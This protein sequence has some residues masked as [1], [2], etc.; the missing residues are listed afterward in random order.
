MAKKDSTTTA[1]IIRFLAIILLFFKKN[2]VLIFPLIIVCLVALLTILKIS[3]TSVGMY[4]EKLYGDGKDSSLIFNHPRSIRSDEWGVNT[5]YVVSQA[6]E[7]FPTTNTSPGNGQDVAFTFDVPTADWSALFKLHNAPFFVLPIEN[8]FALKWWLLAAL[9]MLASYAFVLTLLP[10]RYLLASLISV[11]VFLSPFI[12]WWYQSGSILPITYGLLIATLAIYI[13][14]AKQN[15]SHLKIT[16]AVGALTYALT[17]FAFLLYI[18]FILPIAL[19]VGVFLLGFFLNEQRDDKLPWKVLRKKIVYIV[20]PVIIAAGLSAVFLKTHTVVL[21][22]LSQSV[23]PGQRT[24]P[25]GGFT[26]Q[27]LFGGYFNMQLQDDSR[28]VH[29]DFNQ[30]EASSFILIFPF[31]VPFFMYLWYTT[32]KIDWRALLLGVLFLLFCLRLFVPFAEPLFNLLLLN[33]V[34]HNRLLI[35]IGVLNLLLLIVAAE[36]LIRF[37]KKIPELLVRI[38]V[39]GTFAGVTL[40]GF[41]LKSSYDG[42]LESIPKIILVS[43]VVAVIVWL[44]LKKRFTSA[45]LTLAILSFVSVVAVN[46]LYR[47]LGVLTHSSIMTNIKDLDDH[48][49][50]WIIGDNVAFLETF[51]AVAGAKSLSGVYAYPQLD[52]WKSLGTD[53]D[54]RAVYNRYAHVFFSIESINK[55]EIAQGAYFDPPALDAFRVH[56]DACSLFLRE[57]HVRY[58]LVSQPIDST[59]VAKITEIKYPLADI[60]IYKLLY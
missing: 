60:S 45:F 23:Y 7:G 9:V 18:P 59:C 19:V 42:Y 25:S 28:A 58:I 32:K 38:S 39:A 6:Q 47:G 36:Q 12:H 29:Y 1:K 10:K 20:L 14:K 30:S 43:G 26:L 50:K 55:P 51:P 31:L 27:Q 17:C 21:E 16:L 33:R 8:A 49:S 40:V 15:I 56:A 22:A 2:K 37:K 3:G 52:I 13:F 48:K 54:T 5:P 34:P 35:G 41:L 4:Y 11:G 44:L 24:I 46:P 57:Q 53:L